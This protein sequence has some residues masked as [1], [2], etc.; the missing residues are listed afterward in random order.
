MIWSS[1]ESDTEEED[2]M[3]TDD[4]ES[5]DSDVLVSLS[6]SVC[7]IWHK[8]EIHINTDFAVTGWML[9]VIPQIHKD[10]KDHSD[11]D[12]RNQVNN[13]MKKIFHGVPEEKMAV[14][15]DIVLT[16]YSD[17]DNKIGS[18]D[19]DEF[20]WKSKDIRDGNSHLWHQMYS[21]PCTKVLG[22]C[23]AENSL[24]DL[25]IIKSRKDLLLEVMYQ[26]NRL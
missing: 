7:N 9:C 17:F 23:A 12:D 21:L 25:K 15:Q 14:T 1:S 19:G 2:N 16:E 4:P 8:R 24:G 26:R 18:F 3:D 10:E 20:V 11:S 13:F 22:I 5:I 6:S